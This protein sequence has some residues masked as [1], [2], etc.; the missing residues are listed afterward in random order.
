MPWHKTL[1]IALD[2]GR[3]L[4]LQNLDPWFSSSEIEGMLSELLE[5]ACEARLLPPKGLFLLYFRRSSCSVS[6]PIGSRKRLCKVYRKRFDLG[7][8]GV[9]S[10]C[11]QP[12]TVGFEMGMQW[13]LLQERHCE[14]WNL[15]GK[16]C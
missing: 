2:K 5:V 7:R 8:R 16:E 1:E 10:Q 3:A 4:L 14:A 12:N 15:A 9:T 13:R 6:K 11:A